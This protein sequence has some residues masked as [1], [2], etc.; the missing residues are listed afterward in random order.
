M[1]DEM[2]M[3]YVPRKIMEQRYI[4]MVYGSYIYIM[5]TGIVIAVLTIILMVGQAMGYIKF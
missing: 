2:N 5:A 4:T 3:L 1:A